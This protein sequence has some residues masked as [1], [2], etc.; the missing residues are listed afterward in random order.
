V[1]DPISPGKSPQVEA[2]GAVR[3]LGSDR[4]R[5]GTFHRPR[6]SEAIRKEGSAEST[7]G[8]LISAALALGAAIA[9]YAFLA[10][11]AVPA[12]DDFGQ[13]ATALERGVLSFIQ[14]DYL[15][16]TGRYSSNLVIATFNAAGH[17]LADHFLLKDYFIVPLAL[18]L[19]YLLANFVFFRLVAGSRR[20]GLA[21]L[22]SLIATL[23]ILINTELSS[24]VYW[25]TG[26]A[27]YGLANSL[28][29]ASLAL[30]VHTIFLNPKGVFPVLVNLALIVFI[31]GLS[32]TIMASYAALLVAMLAIN[33]A[34]NSAS[35]RGLAIN[36]AYAAAALASSAAVYFAP[37]NRIRATVEGIQNA[38]RI[39]P[40]LGHGLWSTIINSFHWIISP[41]GIPGPAGHLAGVSGPSRHRGEGGPGSKGD[42]CDHR[43][44][45]RRAVRVLF[46]QVVR[47][48]R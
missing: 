32:E 20:A 4:L 16:W 14:L 24:T 5:R 45:V 33:F 43:E 3:L 23:A 48:E 36:L 39:L 1:S 44:P 46:R 19:L 31:Q 47:H 29:I 13:A 35:R 42:H 22:F 21:L 12:V 8:P 41:S 27:T 10:F 18:I 9:P 26:G 25:L 34:T 7:K 28:F 37:G 17:H 15:N 2:G 6:P 38:H 30:T 40:S 11:F